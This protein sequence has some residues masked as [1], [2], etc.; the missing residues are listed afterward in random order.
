MKSSQNIFY[1]K[2]YL[3]KVTPLVLHLHQSTLYNQP[4]ELAP[5]PSSSDAGEGSN[6]L[7]KSGIVSTN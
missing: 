3:E 1:K 6:S 4:K 7:G 5:R 2:Y